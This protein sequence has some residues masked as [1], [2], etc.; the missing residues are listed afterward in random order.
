MRACTDAQLVAA[1][2]E[3]VP[4]AWAEFDARF[5]PLLETFAR[6]MGV[7]PWD[8]TACVTDVLDDT[9]IRLVTHNEGVPSSLSG[10]LVRAVRYRYLKQLRASRRRERHYTDASDAT[11]SGMAIVRGVVSE[12]ALRASAGPFA[13]GEE[14]HE[15]TG[16]L[17]HFATLLAGE[18]SIDERHMLA[19]V[20]EG[21]PRRQIAAWMGLT[22]EATKKRIS[23]L[24]RRL[25]ELAPSLLTRLR[26]AERREVE[27]F[28]RRVAALHLAPARPTR[29]ED[30][31]DE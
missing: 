24:S 6:R 21:V 15:T 26:P 14:R 3:G 9:A 10:Y 4:E 16:T 31:D 7:P 23:R 13:V 1:M 18:L 19:W 30:T 8:G 22:Y 29:M 5:R 27:R 17:A 20:G 11:E 25:R 12:D 28:L 2:R